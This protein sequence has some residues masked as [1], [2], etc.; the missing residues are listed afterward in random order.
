MK[1]TVALAKEDIMDN[2]RMSPL[3]R[4]EFHEDK[5]DT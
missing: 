3:A 1:K 2:W 4:P 5:S